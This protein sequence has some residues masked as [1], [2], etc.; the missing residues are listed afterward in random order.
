MRYLTSISLALVVLMALACTSSD[1]KISA[2]IQAEISATQ[3]AKEWERERGEKFISI[4][5]DHIERG[6]PIQYMLWRLVEPT[7]SPEC[8]PG[9]FY[10]LS[11]YPDF[12][13]EEKIAMKEELR[14]DLNSGNLDQ[15]QFEAKYHEDYLWSEDE[16]CHEWH[17]GM[18]N[19]ERYLAQGIEIEKHDLRSR[20]FFRW[21][22]V[23]I[24][25]E[26][27]KRAVEQFPELGKEREVGSERW[28]KQNIESS[29]HWRVWANIYL[30]S[31]YWLV[32]DD[33]DAIYAAPR[34]MKH[35]GP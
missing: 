24:S 19:R 4:V 31:C 27:W 5:I 2:T 7:P 3:T 13:M 22:A 26:Y 9:L 35:N 14:A 8:A 1:A 21:R 34:E 15:D 12:C 18:G 30:V 16:Q 25:A 10:L 28:L 23:F 20:G 17:Q 6:V 33:G 11:D 32:S 29:D